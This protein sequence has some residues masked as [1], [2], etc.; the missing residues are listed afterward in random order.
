[1]SKN[2]I[3]SILSVIFSILCLSFYLIPQITAQEVD[4]SI[5]D[6][7]INV[8][9]N[10]DGSV[11]F[12]D[13]QYYDAEFMNGVLFDLDHKGYDLSN[14]TVGVSDNKEGTITPLERST[15]QSKNTYLTEEQ[16]GILKTKVFY[17]L[18]NEGKYFV[19]HYKLDQLVT[20]YQDTAE[21]LRQFGRSEHTTDVEI[22]IE[23]PEKASR[24]EDVR[25]WG[26]GAPQGQVKIVEEAGKSVIYLNVPNRTA[27]QFVEG[28]IV[29]PNSW[30]A[31][32]PNK[33]NEKRL[34]QIISKAEAQ[35]EKD[36]KQAKQT[37]FLRAALAIAASIFAPI[38]AL[39]ALLRYFHQFKKLNPQPVYV[40]DYLYDLPERISPGQMATRYLRH[41]PTEDDF[42]ATLLHLVQKGWLKLETIPSGKKSDETIIIT[43]LYSE[44]NYPEGMLAHE[45]YVW[46]Y[47]TSAKENAGVTLAEIDQLAKKNATFRK[48]QFSYW[49]RF[50]NKLTVEGE[51][52]R[53]AALEMTKK[54]NGMLLMALFMMG[55]SIGLTIYFLYKQDEAGLISENSTSTAFVILSIS[56]LLTVGLLI[57]VYSLLKWRPLLT[58][59]QQEMGD[60][61][62]AFAKMLKD[63]GRFKV[64]E[65]ASLPLWEEF[66]VYATSLGVADKVVKAIEMEFDA[67]EIQ[68]Q[69]QSLQTLSQPYLYSQILRSQVSQ[70]IHSVTPQ[71]SSQS[72]FSGNNSGG[73]GGGFSGGSMGG[74]GGGT[75]SGGF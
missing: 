59:Q 54:I 40:P 56:I 57:L 63:I 24:K 55:V 73:F 70:S 26:Y 53:G 51:K 5:T 18:E 46:D 42:V 16:D 20:N 13:F 31:S 74:S 32:N 22:R 44:S 6:Q 29:F 52:Y 25:A 67:S 11:D 71:P 7:F 58:T 17:P 36:A 2:R 50:K 33:V 38:I 12:T 66:L 65:I 61:W 23:L 30:T 45:E 62:K 14:F 27:A 4:F 72:S 1:M 3:Q 34:D 43:P 35:V 64:R 69:G 39:L 41:Q 28:H 9:V 49:T 75:H 60:K 48:K 15:S 21:L 10:E 8:E 47:F 19:F 37:S 68:A